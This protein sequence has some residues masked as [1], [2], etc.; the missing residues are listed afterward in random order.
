MAVF[1]KNGE[2]W[3]DYYVSGQRSLKAAI[4]EDGGFD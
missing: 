1:K 3:I 4:E 2:W